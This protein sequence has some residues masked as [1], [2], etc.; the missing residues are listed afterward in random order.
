MCSF[1]SKELVSVDLKSSQPYF[2][3]SILLKENPNNEQV[4]RFYNL[5]TQHDIYDWLEEKFG[6]FSETHSRQESRQFIK[7]WFF[8]Y[9]YKSNSG[10]TNVQN[11]M[12]REFNEVYQ[13]IK[14]RKRK[15]ELWL[16]LQKIEAEI[17][18]PTCNRYVERGCLSVHDA[19]Y[20][21]AELQEEVVGSLD[22][23]FKAQG[24]S[25]YKL[26]SGI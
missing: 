6:G 2:L 9:L 12:M 25:G 13:L 14:E 23:G 20:F 1:N 7:E 11:I 19:L 21:P 26:D 17:F 16:T 5:I 15:E 4:Q 22:L 18:I 8:G 10:T 24:F 3:A